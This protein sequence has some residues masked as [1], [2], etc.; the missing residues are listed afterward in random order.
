MIVA[1]TPQIYN[2]VLN[3]DSNGEVNLVNDY[4]YGIVIQN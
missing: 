3:T 2:V 4:V 1:A